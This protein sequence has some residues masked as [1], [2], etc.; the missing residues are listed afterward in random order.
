MHPYKS[1][2][3]AYAAAR[4]E[5]GLMVEWAADA[6][7][8]KTV[9][10]ADASTTLFAGVVE[11]CVEESSGVFR[12]TFVRDGIG[13]VRYGATFTRGTHTGHFKSDAAGKATPA[14]TGDSYCGTLLMEDNASMTAGGLGRCA[15]RP[16]IL[17]S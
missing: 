17:G 4:I 12:V 9:V 11:D 1:N 2:V 8:R 15:V 7:G 5:P 3:T 14:S 16:G 13:R 6:G 10:V